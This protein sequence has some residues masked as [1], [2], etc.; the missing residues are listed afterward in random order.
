MFRRPRERGSTS[1]VDRL[2]DAKILKAAEPRLQYMEKERERDR[3]REREEE[4]ERKQ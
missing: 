2:E 3:K 4:R 1:L